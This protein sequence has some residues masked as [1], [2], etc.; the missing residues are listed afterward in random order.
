MNHESAGSGLLCLRW[1]RELLVEQE[2]FRK[3]AMVDLT[4]CRPSKARPKELRSSDITLQSSL[5]YRG[6]ALTGQM[7]PV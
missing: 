3:R 2:R 6:R 5:E 1:K 7:L 4:G